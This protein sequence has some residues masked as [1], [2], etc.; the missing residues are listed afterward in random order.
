MA[1]GI[2]EIMKNLIKNIIVIAFITVI[3]SIFATSVRAEV[4][5]GYDA[6]ITIQKDGRLHVTEKIDYD[7]EYVYKHGIYREIPF[8]KKNSDGKEFE[9]D[10]QVQSIQDEEGNSYNYT[11][12]RENN[13]V[14]IK[15]GDANKTITGL[16]IYIIEY[17]VSGALTYFSDHDELYWNITGTEWLANQENVSGTVELP[18]GVDMQLVKTLCFTGAI[19]ST[20]QDCKVFSEN[21]KTS[22]S[23]PYIEKGSGFTIAVSFPKGL[24][25]ILEPKPYTAFEN[26]W[27]GKL[28]LVVIFIFIGILA[29]IWYVGIPLY[30]PI[31]WYLQGRDPR[32][33]DVRVWYDP[34]QT[35]KGRKLTP[36][37]TGALVDEIVDMRDIVGS[38]VHL[39]QRGYFQIVEDK[40]K[41]LTLVKKNDWNTDVSLI[42]FERILLNGLF[43][44]KDE[45]KLKG[46]DLSDEIRQVNDSLYSQVVK[47]GFFSSD[48]QATRN[49]YYML[50]G[51]GLFTGNIP[52]AVIG[53]IFA[54]FMP[55]KTVDGTQQASIGR[56]LKTFLT[57][58]ERQLEFQ[59]KNQ[60]RLPSLSSGISGQVMFE[61]LLPYAVVFGVEKIWAGR[62]KDI[63]LTQPS[64]YSGQDAMAF[65]AM[66]LSNRLHSSVSTLRS[67]A[68][69]T[70]SSTGH[71]SGFSGGFSGGGGGGGG[72]GSW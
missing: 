3:N 13:K 15:I 14:R 19:K 72:G 17:V 10:I 33:Q 64:W 34:P 66:Y 45:C 30:I 40:K 63:A 65:N 12:S 68:T 42:P 53:F 26:T 8:I 56:S 58:Q 55:A 9:V 23:T 41:D 37:E 2:L 51:A 52:L 69:P 21:I 22:V 31:K 11:E 20:S 43:G 50:A 6:Q 32:S 36:A 71:S 24:V 46:K 70:R 35:K 28:I 62:F 38:L 18:E 5:R 1:N 49:K 27:Y 61:K 59:A 29:F 16:H 60:T 39:A 4:I 25:A 57:S 7:F 44:A 67:S 48:P 47:E 54:K